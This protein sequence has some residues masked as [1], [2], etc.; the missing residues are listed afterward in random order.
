MVHEEN[1]GYRREDQSLPEYGMAERTLLLTALGFG[2]E[3]NAE[4]SSLS[5]W[6]SP[7]VRSFLKE[8]CQ[9]EALP[10]IGF[11]QQT[12]MLRQLKSHRT[13][14]PQAALA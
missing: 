11:N 5:F 8:K 14:S 1:Q 7:T 12:K 4:P 13:V 10:F 3:E 6:P 2:F 9:H